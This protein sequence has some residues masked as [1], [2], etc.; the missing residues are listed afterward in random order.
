M[1]ATLASKPDDAD[2]RAVVIPAGLFSVPD[3][4][5]PLDLLQRV[6]TVSRRAMSGCL[7]TL[8]VC[9]CVVSGA[10]TLADESPTV[11]ELDDQETLAALKLLSE[12]ATAN[13]ANLS[14]LEATYAL[15]DHYRIHPE[16]LKAMKQNPPEEPGPWDRND[17]GV[18]TLRYDAADRSIF[19]DISVSQS[20]LVRDSQWNEINFPLPLPAAQRNILTPS[21]YYYF[22]YAD[23]YSDF[24]EVPAMKGQVGR[25]AFREPIEEAARHRLG[26]SIDP[27]DLFGYSG[28]TWSEQLDGLASLL[29]ADLRGEIKKPEGVASRVVTVRSI[30]EGTSHVYRVAFKMWKSTAG[31]GAGGI[32]FVLRF[33]AASSYMCE[34]MTAI[35]EE[36]HDVE[37][38]A[39]QTK[40]V[41]GVL[42]PEKAIR[43]V[44]D[45]KTHKPISSRVLALTSIRVN[46]QCD[47]TA[48]D[49]KMLG[50][51]DGERVLDR[52]E[53]TC[54]LF[55]GGQL[56][57]P[58]SF[59][60][61]AA[62]NRPSETETG[63]S[64]GGSNNR[65][66]TMGI[67]NAVIIALLFAVMRRRGGQTG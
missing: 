65:M 23:R 18:V 61:P 63:Q 25:V 28:R 27:R 20:A 47:G 56:V 12:K 21:H 50:L 52:V 38:C 19:S 37:Q 51:D 15:D 57:E 31:K 33:P 4:R 34:S 10:A 17:L 13:F 5:Q 8:L 22:R 32:D 26:A 60:A 40:D 16:A 9:C 11:K 55:K 35:N 2:V 30:G 58:V 3:R 46:E 7:A 48:I 6:R 44:I 66:M 45:P 43:T 14:L 54:F 59:H 36:G 42:V 53:E 39:W 62:S 49:V 24:Q 64:T 29:E 67:A 1:P 41:G